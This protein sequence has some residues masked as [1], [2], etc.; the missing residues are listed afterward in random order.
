MAPAPA[1]AQAAPPTGVFGSLAASAQSFTA[2]MPQAPAPASVR[3]PAMAPTGSVQNQPSPTAPHY[4]PLANYAPA[5]TPQAYPAPA[6]VVAVPAAAGAQPPFPNASLPTL[7]V[8]IKVEDAKRRV[9]DRLF[10]IRAVEILLQLV[11]LFEYECDL[12]KEGSLEYDTHDGRIQVHGSD[13]TTLDV[14]PDVTNPH[15]PSLLSDGH[16]YTV[17]E[18][19]LRVA[20]DRAQQ[21]AFQHVVTKHTRKVS[22]RVPDHNNSLFYTEKRNVAPTSQQIRL[23]HIGV[24]LRP[25]WRLHGSNGIADIDATDGRELMSEIRGGRTD[26]MMIE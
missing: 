8:R 10:S 20:Q 18:R 4:A 26:A 19:V 25:V 12:L 5:P 13:K 24:H 14:D 22:V 23:H 3:L 21:L 9:K 15:A 16:P 17:E 1:A 6:P 2:P 11:H 7:P